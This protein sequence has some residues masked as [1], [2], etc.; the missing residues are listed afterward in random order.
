MGRNILG[1]ISSNRVRLFSDRVNYP[2][3]LMPKS[4]RFLDTLDV[5]MAQDLTLM[6]SPPWRDVIVTSC[7]LS[8]IKGAGAIKFSLCVPGLGQGFAVTSSFAALFR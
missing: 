5:F 8:N 7:F 1:N 3:I 2:K 4:S 6:S